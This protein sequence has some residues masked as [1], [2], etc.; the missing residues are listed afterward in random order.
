MRTRVNESEGG[1]CVM[2]VS[3]SESQ[4]ESEGGRSQRQKTEV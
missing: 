4:S 3:E 1:R 2:S